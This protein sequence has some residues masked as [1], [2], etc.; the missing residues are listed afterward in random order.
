MAKGMFGKLFAKRDHGGLC[1]MQID[2]GLEGS[3]CECGNVCTSVAAEGES[4]YEEVV[5]I[6][7]LGP[8]C[9]K[10]HQLHDNAIEAVRLADKRACVEYVT[11]MAEIVAAGVMA[12]PGLMI[13]GKL[14]SSGKVLTSA[15]IGKMI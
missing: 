6:K 14:V 15:E 4:L 10:C 8:G 11:D 13:D 1:D 12:T 3:T 7:V 5:L 2:E 9:K